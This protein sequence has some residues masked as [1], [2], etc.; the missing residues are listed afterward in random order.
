MKIRHISLMMLLLC[1]G[2]C[3]DFLDAKPDKALLVP[4]TLNDM[5]LLFNDDGR[6]NVTQG[7]GILSDDDHIIT[8]VAWEALRTPTE[9]N[10][11]IWAKD[12]L[13]GTGT[14]QWNTAYEQVF[15]ANVVLTGLE[16]LKLK[17]GEEA[18]NKRLKGAAYFFR[19]W[20]Y[21]HTASAFA[22]QYEFNTASQKA[23]IP[24]Y[25][26][27]DV[28]LRPGRGTL[29]NI[30]AQIETD[31][32]AA[33]EN[34]PIITDY[35]T[36]PNRAAAFA[37]QSR[38]YLSMAKYPEAS[39]AADSCLKYQN[40]ILDY[41]TI[42]ATAARPFNRNTN[43]E[44]IFQN[45][46]ISFSV[47]TNTGTVITPSLFSSYSSNDIRRTAFFSTGVNGPLFK[48]SY[49]GTTNLFAGLSV[50]EVYLNRAECRAR[51]NNMIGSMSDLNALLIKRF[52]TNTYVPLVAADANIAL[53]LVLRERR[54]ELLFRGLRWTDLKRLNLESTLAVT[55]IR[56]LKGETYTL[57]PNDKRYVLPIPDE[58]I[59]LGGLSPNDR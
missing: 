27:A 5:E 31:L 25:L 38:V 24:V 16:N 2:A 10:T 59:N 26:I 40:I 52:R 41:N 34:L 50:D 15:N 39:I 37:L 19:A 35:K 45:R 13:E 17:T 14:S 53:S 23:G 3:S 54:K 47:F 36:R 42:T 55:L 48:G 7:L 30:Y 33:V 57:L 58:E 20:A 11:Y 1:L 21:Y 9:K 6:M 43:P 12:I 46:V 32:K 22:A 29:A 51:A 18:Q 4:T 56:T 49:D 8:D 28:N 44:I